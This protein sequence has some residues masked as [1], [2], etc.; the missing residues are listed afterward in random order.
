MKR[1]IKH[2]NSARVD[3]KNPLQINGRYYTNTITYNKTH[4]DGSVTC[5]SEENAE[6]TRIDGNRI[7]LS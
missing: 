1:L 2:G 5:A 3:P 4:S 7:R 6:Q